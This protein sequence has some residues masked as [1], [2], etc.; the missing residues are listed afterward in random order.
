[1][2][3]GNTVAVG[4]RNVS[5]HGQVYVFVY[6]GGSWS[7]QAVLAP[8]GSGAAT[9][10]A[11]VA[12]SDD[13]NTLAVGDYAESSNAT[14]INGDPN[15]SLAQGSGAVLVFTRSG[16]TWTQQA[17]IKASNTEAGDT[18][19]QAVALSADGNTLAVGAYNE[20]SAATGVNGDQS[21]NSALSSGAVYVYTRAGTQWSQQAYV[22]AS[23]TESNDTFGLQLALSADG[24]V[25][26]VGTFNEA[27]NGIG[28]DADQDDNSALLSG[29]VYVFERGAAA[30][31]QRSYVKASNT[32]NEDF[33]GAAVALSGDG[34][35]M[36]VGAPGES[37][38]S[39]GVGG[40]QQN[41]G[42]GFS[43][44]VYLY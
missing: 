28:V 17:Y 23:N 44:A 39:T 42:A 30:W 33:F 21:D 40:D 43:G 19:G 41:N 24:R 6:S 34:S 25:L 38:S 4:A 35:V 3:D 13:G 26:A 15:N 31:S 11:V 18:F 5:P 9:F 14:G 12:L 27:G 10:G 2:S 8:S 29:A 7:Q 22:K 20:S 1:S 32:Q 36:A 37:S 16:S